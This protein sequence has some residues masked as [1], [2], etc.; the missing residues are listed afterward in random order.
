MKPKLSQVMS[1][2]AALIT[3]VSLAQVA[4]ASP[5]ALSGKGISNLGM[6]DNSPGSIDTSIDTS[7]LTSSEVNGLSDFNAWGLAGLGFAAAVATGG[8]LLKGW[9]QR[10]H[11]SVSEASSE[12]PQTHLSSDSAFETSTFAIEV[13]PEALRSLDAVEETIE[14]DATLV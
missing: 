11:E 13:P 12:A 10:K 2:A 6:S 1:L 14:S 5:C 3:A 8:V 4:S 9:L 7:D